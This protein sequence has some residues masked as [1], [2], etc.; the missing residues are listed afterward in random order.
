MS[1]QNVHLDIYKIGHLVITKEFRDEVSRSNVIKEASALVGLSAHPGLPVVLGVDVSTKPFLLISLFYGMNESNTSLHNL[2]N[3][4]EQFRAVKD[5]EFLAIIRQLS[6][7]LEYLHVH[8]LLHNNIKCD[9][10]MIYKDLEG[11]KPVLIDFGKACKLGDGKS[12]KLTDAEKKKYRERH[13]HIAPEIVEGTAP[14]TASSD[15]FALGRIILKIGT[16]LNCPK[17]IDLSKLCTSENPAKR[18]TLSFLVEECKI[19]NEQL[20]N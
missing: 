2:L 9:N 10:V 6:E 20:A 7:V 17:I 19:V 12:K 1:S 14:Q 8:Q 15:I 5:I 13:S 16:R 11:L 3:V 4:D 18:C